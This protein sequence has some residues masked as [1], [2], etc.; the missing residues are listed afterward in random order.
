MIEEAVRFVIA[1]IFAILLLFATGLL[2]TS[3]STVAKCIVR[4]NT[5]NPCN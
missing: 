3:C 4:D 1:S 2:L 5:S